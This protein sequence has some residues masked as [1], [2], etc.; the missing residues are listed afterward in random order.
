MAMG[1]AGASALA[2]AH[3]P[4]RTSL[5]KCATLLKKNLIWRILL[6]GSVHAQKEGPFFLDF[7]R[8]GAYER[9]G[10]H[11]YYAGIVQGFAKVL[12]TYGSPLTTALIQEIHKECM[13]I[14]IVSGSK[15]SG[16]RS[17]GAI[18]SFAINFVNCT[19]AGLTE[20]ILRQLEYRKYKI[21]A[22]YPN[23]H[24]TTYPR[25]DRESL[26]SLEHLEAYMGSEK[27]VAPIVERLYSTLTGPAK[28]IRFFVTQN[29]EKW[30]QIEIARYEDAIKKATDDDTKLNAIVEFVRNS[31]QI[32]PFH[33]GNCRTMYLLLQKLL[34]E[35]NFSPTLLEDP[36]VLDMYD[37]S[38]LVKL[39]KKGFAKVEQLLYLSRT[40][41]DRS[42]DEYF[43]DTLNNHEFLRLYP[44]YL[45][46]E[47]FSVAYQADY[48]KS[49]VKLE[50]AM[51]M[52]MEIA[53]FRTGREAKIIDNSELEA[54]IA[55][56]DHTA[57]ASLA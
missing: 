16:F 36:N 17:E 39:V 18:A 12:E 19:K 29:P 26:L 10:E 40:A 43:H 22:P 44:D 6:D 56:R 8:P 54:A 14:S 46:A 2:F 55:A 34:I 25:E 48:Q 41:Q 3:S 32:H 13:P 21:L 50:K 11:N 28:C 57:A 1:G 27:E 7:Y 45:E 49:L 30:L 47:S 15:P 37:V 23:F 51:E 35:N 33:D 52:A 24:F 53:R 9:D 42:A 38:A 4:V 5:E 20:F 31:E